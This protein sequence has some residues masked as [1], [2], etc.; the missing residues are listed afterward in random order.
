MTSSVLFRLRKVGFGELA[1]GASDKILA[2]VAFT[3]PHRVVN[4]L[5]LLLIKAQL[6]L[7][8]CHDVPPSRVIPAPRMARETCKGGYGVQPLGACMPVLS[9]EF[10]LAIVTGP[11][12]TSAFLDGSGL[13]FTIASIISTAARPILTGC[14]ATT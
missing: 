1:Q 3:G 8:R 14:C 13:P 7:G 11:S 4:Q 6:D 9:V 10:R 2:A 5:E 12:G